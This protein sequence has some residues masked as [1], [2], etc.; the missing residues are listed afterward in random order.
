[1][2]QHVQEQEEIFLEPETQA[3]P[4]PE[5]TY[6]ESPKALKRKKK[7]SI[8]AS[9]DQSDVLPRKKQKQIVPRITEQTSQ[10]SPPPPSKSS[11]SIASTSRLSREETDEQLFGKSNKLPRINPPAPPLRSSYTTVSPRKD[12][13]PRLSP[14]P[15]SRA[16][17]TT[18]QNDL[19]LK[20]QRRAQFANGND[21][22][23]VE[24]VPV[25][26]EGMVTSSGTV[27]IPDSQLSSFGPMEENSSAEAEPSSTQQDH[28]DEDKEAEQEEEAEAAEK[29]AESTETNDD[30]A[31]P[32]NRQRPNQVIPLLSP[33]PTSILSR[34]VTPILKNSTQISDDAINPALL[35]S[36]SKT[37]LIN[38][39]I[40]A[41][42]TK[43]VVLRPILIPTRTDFIISSQTTE[44]DPIIDS[45]PI[46]DAYSRK[47][48]IGD[49][50]Q[51]LTMQMENV[52][53]I[54]EEINGNDDESMN[55]AVPF[56][57]F[58]SEDYYDQ[59]QQE[60]TIKA[61]VVQPVPVDTV[62]FKTDPVR[63][64]SSPDG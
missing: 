51:P 13:L 58:L 22:A 57:D 1:M 17:S 34:E 24:L 55:E 9:D 40:P 2:E 32:F 41:A 53:P 56:D 28:A 5:E 61:I 33:V 11:S 50:R 26:K 64:P 14:S 30:I 38:K 54:G 36:K 27:I 39:A 23:G 62:I 60:V 25:Q 45:S 21:D 6:H 42:S 35:L 8:A 20:V 3:N 47:S 18:P 59:T 43:A 19:G 63:S 29:E 48:T 10:D 31:Q 37:A 12:F 46:K 4:I 16:S 52:E 49:L 7:N 15:S 44:M